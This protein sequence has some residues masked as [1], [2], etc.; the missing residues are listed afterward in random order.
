[1]NKKVDK[2]DKK[3][4]TNPVREPKNKA[5]TNAEKE[6]LKLITEDFLT[7]K[8]IQ[9][10]RQ[11]SRQAVYKIL[12]KLKEKGALN[13]G[14]QK[15][16][17]IEGVVNQNLIRLHGQE[18]NIKILHQNESY[19]KQLKSS[20]LIFIDGHTIKL[21][22]NSIELYAGGGQSFYGDTAQMAIS[23]SLAYWKRFIAR[24]E[25][26][27]NVILVKPRSRNIRI[28]N[29]HFARGESEIC[30]NA[31]EN[32]KR[33]KVYAEEDGKLAFITDDSFGFKEDETIHPLT[34]KPDREAIDKQV[35]DW[36]VHNPPTN[37]QL[38]GHVLQNAQNL[39]QYAIHLKAHVKS[40]QD[41]GEGT[42]IMNM[43]LK[44]IETAIDKL[45]KL[46]GRSNK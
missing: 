22:K 8:Q 44:N 43:S 16:D 4:L 25:H 31:I 40:V 13:V 46:I 33:I 28:V 19:Q 21:Y 18:F 37:S 20:N 23:K 3:R 26:D 27:F 41:L 5:L 38:A 24:L 32:H 2:V 10:R 42:K 30:E 12:K 15:V 29:Q 34:S 6:V 36:R 39:D 17:K 14:L 35:N 45:T 1:M 11:C 7:L 9:I